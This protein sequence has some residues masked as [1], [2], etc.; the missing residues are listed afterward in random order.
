VHP[1]RS[2]QRCICQRPHSERKRQSVIDD[3]LGH[4][5]EKCLLPGQPEAQAAALSAKH[6]GL[7]FSKAEIEA[8]NEIARECGAKPWDIASFKEMRI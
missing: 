4:G 2:D 3:I 6:G 1:S 7:L 5:N 8:F